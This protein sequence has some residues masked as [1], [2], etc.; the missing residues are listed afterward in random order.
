M[1]CPKCG[2]EQ[3]DSAICAK[4]GIVVAKFMQRQRLATNPAEA[5]KAVVPSFGP[6]L[7]GPKAFVFPNIPADL[8]S[9]A[10]GAYPPEEAV[11]VNEEVLMLMLESA[12]TGP[13]T[14]ALLTTRRLIKTEHF[15]GRISQI[16]LADLRTAKLEGGLL[17]RIMINGSEFNPLFVEANDVQREKDFAAMLAQIVRVLGMAGPGGVFKNTLGNEY[18]SKGLSP[19]ENI[20]PAIAPAIAPGPP[21]LGIDSAPPPRDHFKEFFQADWVDPPAAPPPDML[22]LAASPHQPRQGTMAPDSV[23]TYAAPGPANPASLY[24]AAPPVTAQDEDLTETAA[25][26]AGRSIVAN[27]I[28][29]LVGSFVGMPIGIFIGAILHFKDPGPRYVGIFLGVIIWTAVANAI[30]RAGN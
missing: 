29:F 20:A 14:N 19:Q 26:S 28:G 21:P 10:V 7:V 6:R 2:F 9:A 23:N 17:T 30:K 8:L 15:L 16:A 18:P 4:C 12:A 11:G 13:R 24:R 27:I 5:V 25:P 3:P 1:Q 22:E